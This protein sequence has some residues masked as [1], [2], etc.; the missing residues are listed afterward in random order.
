ML[1]R[2]IDASSQ[3]AELA[4]RLDSASLL[5]EI[6]GLLSVRA[7]MHAGRLM[8]SAPDDA[9]GAPAPGTAAP[10]AARQADAVISGSVRGMMSLLRGARPAAAEGR[11]AVTI[12][13]DAEVANLYRQ[14]FI[15]ARPDWEEELSRWIGDAPARSLVR[16][17]GGIMGW[18]QRTHRT[19]GENIAEYLKEESR[20]LVARTEIEE[21]LAG[22]DQVREAADRVEARLQGLQRRLG[23]K[24]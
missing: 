20:D 3:A 1:N 12:R 24:A 21:F 19:I 9:P 15:A 22:V 18:A 10:G 2:G 4:R 7:A 5:V 23:D 6:E 17:A 14:L 16:L 11:A 13:G 8:L